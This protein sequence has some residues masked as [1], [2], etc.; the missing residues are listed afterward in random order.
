MIFYF[1]L[2]QRQLQ[3]LGSLWF[4]LKILKFQL[5]LA[6]GNLGRLVLLKENN[7]LLWALFLSLVLFQPQPYLIPSGFYLHSFFALLGIFRGKLHTNFLYHKFSP[8]SQLYTSFCQHTP[9]LLHWFFLFFKAYSPFWLFSILNSKLSCTENLFLP[10][11]LVNPGIFKGL[12]LIYSAWSTSVFFPLLSPFSYSKF[13]IL[14]LCL[15]SARIWNLLLVT[16]H[17]SRRYSTRFFFPPFYFL[18]E[19]TKFSTF[20]IQKHDWALTGKSPEWPLKLGVVL[21]S[22]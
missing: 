19:K 5:L 10:F 13:C 7:F 6:P 12:G 1:I 15:L 22:I 2:G 9:L 3:G 16:K 8:S 18:Q 20:C 14:L 11:S 17:S 4:I 21:G